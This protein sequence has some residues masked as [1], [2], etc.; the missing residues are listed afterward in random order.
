MD[1][2]RGF[3]VSTEEIIDRTQSY[4]A[5]RGHCEPHNGTTK[6]GHRKCAG[7]AVSMRRISRSDIGLCSGV[8][9][10]PTRAS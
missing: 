1:M 2:M 7:L 9:A 10:E 6:E 8:H 3:R 4:K 5:K